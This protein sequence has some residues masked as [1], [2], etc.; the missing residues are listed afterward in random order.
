MATEF[1]FDVGALGKTSGAVHR[2]VVPLGATLVLAHGAGAPR[3]HPFMIATADRLA[4]KGLDV[5]TFN[6]LYAEAARKLPDRADR[7]EATWRAAI[8]AVRA[9]RELPTDRLFVGGKSMGGRMATRIAA[10]A[11]ASALSGVIL[12]GYPLHPAGKPTVSRGEILHVS[13]PMLVVQGSRDTLGTAAEMRA[14]LGSTPTATVHEVEGGDHS[15]ALPKKEGTAR[16]EQA[17]DGAMDAIVAFVTTTAR[18]N[19]GPNAG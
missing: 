13:L 11:G 12:L 14:L 19:A 15:L 8:A 4:A 10:A 2:A 5:V 9:R 17:L 3:T 1:S 16:Q 6:F 18:R 7:L